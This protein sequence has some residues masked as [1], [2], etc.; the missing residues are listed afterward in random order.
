MLQRFI[1]WWIRNAVHIG[2]LATSVSALAALLSVY[3]VTKTF[4]QAQKDRVAELVAKHPKFKIEFGELTHNTTFTDRQRRS[5]EH[6]QPIPYE[7]TVG[8]KNINPNTATDITFV[9]EIY[10]E[11]NGDAVGR[12]TA[13]PSDDLDQDEISWIDAK[14]ELVDSSTPYFLVVTATYRDARTSRVYST[15]HWRSFTL[16]GSSPVHLLKLDKAEIRRFEESIHRLTHS[17]TESA[18]KTL[19]ASADK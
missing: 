19:P 7:L 10:E 9:G 8:L 16:T 5:G 4:R 15:N 1:A 12:F 6:L 17:E 13:E 3:M 2:P 11:G 14:L 18:V